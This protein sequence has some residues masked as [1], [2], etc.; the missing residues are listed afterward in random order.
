MLY[1]VKSSI[2]NEICEF[3]KNIEWDL[4]ESRNL[5]EKFIKERDTEK[6]S[7]VETLS[8]W[9]D[10][11]ALSPLIQEF[12]LRMLKQCDDDTIRLFMPQLVMSMKANKD[13]EICEYLVR[14]CVN[15]DILAI[16]FFWHLVVE[17]EKTSDK[18]YG[19]IIYKFMV[20]LTKPENGCQRRDLLRKQGELVEKLVKI[21]GTIR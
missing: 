21:S 11:Y 10:E 12:N 18:F 7:F 1:F 15:T 20:H 2:A 17:I 3:L 16:P 5:A 19:R 14:R 13:K 4:E 9:K 6:V 8:L